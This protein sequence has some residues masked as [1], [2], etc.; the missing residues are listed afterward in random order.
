MNSASKNLRV[1]HLARWYPNR[2]DPMP[3]LFIQRHIEAA[4]LYAPQAA[5]YVHPIENPKKEDRFELIQTQENNVLT[6]RIYYRPCAS[7]IAFFRKARNLY[8]F[9]RAVFKGIQSVKVSFPFEVI[10]IHIL[11]RLGL[12]G[13]FY[14]FSKGVPYVISEHWSRYLSHVNAFRGWG[15]KRITRW[16]TQ[17][18][19][20]VT[21]VTHNL[22][23]A[24]KNHGL[25]N[26]NYIL[27]ENVVAPFFYEIRPI[28]QT[29]SKTLHLVHV[30]CFEDRSK[31]ISGLLRVF[32]SLK[33]RNVPFTCKMIGE[34]MDLE[35]MKEYAKKLDLKEPHIQFLG[36]KQGKDLASLMASADAL[37]M[38]SHFE[39]LPVVINESL[40]LGIPVVSTNVGGIAEYLTSENGILV[41]RNDED[42]L[43]DVLTKLGNSFFH[44]NRQAISAASRERFSAEAIGQKLTDIYHQALS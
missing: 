21:T 25:Q 29:I 19:S 42:G 11:S 5:V 4:A 12:I 14:S 30:S 38:F 18:A 33:E 6:C 15:R 37:V 17:N 2:Y 27:L 3:G 32:Q 24:M 16:I 40:V 36:L 7:P 10:H 39:N 20:A 41:E 8:L 28:H 44:F 35:A 13:W 1:L 22:A 31:N 43:V 23:E 34:G 9:Y 26:E